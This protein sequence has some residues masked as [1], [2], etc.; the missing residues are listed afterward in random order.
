[1]SGQTPPRPTSDAFPTGQ[2]AQLEMV[3]RGGTL[4]S[5]RDLYARGVPVLTGVKRRGMRRICGRGDLT[6]VKTAKLARPQGWPGGQDGSDACE[7]GRGRG[8]GGVHG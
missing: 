5:T 8:L 7:A 6:A 1:M 2:V 4:R 3:V